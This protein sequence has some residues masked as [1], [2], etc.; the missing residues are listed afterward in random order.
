MAEACLFYSRLCT[1]RVW[2]GETPVPGNV[3]STRGPFQF[4]RWERLAWLIFS[5]ASSDATPTYLWKGLLAVGSQGCDGGPASSKST[6]HGGLPPGS[7]GIHKAW[8]GLVQ[9]PP[10]IESHVNG[11]LD[12][13]LC[14]QAWSGLV[15]VPREEGMQQSTVENAVFLGDRTSS[16]LVKGWLHQL[17]S[18][19]C[20]A[21][22]TSDVVRVINCNI[23]N[24]A[25]SGCLPAVGVSME[26]IQTLASSASAEGFQGTTMPLAYSARYQGSFNQERVC[27]TG[28][29]PQM[30]DAPPHGCR[31][32]S[33]IEEPL[34][35]ARLE[36]C[37]PFILER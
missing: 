33:G 13:Y 35:W 4:A 10:R 6:E 30:K 28:I 26:G 12:L 34:I 22:P 18:V 7:E 19:A 24:T 11:G 1:C 21:S 32:L 37:H 20:D 14:T 5:I 8:S 9:V 3:Q 29:E 17:F 2:D 16:G 25:L 27:S 36:S 23:D 15:Q 31:S